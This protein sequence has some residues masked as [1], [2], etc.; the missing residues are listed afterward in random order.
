MK[1]RILA[2]LLCVVMAF[3][4][5]CLG[6][7]APVYAEGE[8]GSGISDPGETGESEIATTINLRTVTVYMTGYNEKGTNTRDGMAVVSLAGKLVDT[9][10][11]DADEADDGFVVT[12]TSAP[13][14]LPADSISFSD[15][16]VTFEPVK[17]GSSVVDFTVGTQAFTVKV[18]CYKPAMSASLLMYKKQKKTLKVTGIPSGTSVKFTSSNPKIA[19]VSSTG[20]VTAKVSGNAVIY[21]SVGT[22]KLG[23][24]VSV[25]TK[26]KYRAINRAVKM[27]RTCRYSQPKR[28]RKGYYDCSSMVWRSYKPEKIYI[29]SKWFA[30]VAASQAKYLARKKKIYCKLSYANGQSMRYRAGDLLFKTGAKNR[31]YKGI[32]H[33]EM[34]RGYTFLGYTQQNRS[35]VTTRWANRL[36]GYADDSWDPGIMGRP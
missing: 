30:P 1:R 13:S 8:S 16:R 33:V 32:Y 12:Y 23:C 25:A 31:R 9:G 36:D 15:D 4:G 5:L 19:T 24:V 28:M 29:G 34:F 2:L 18:T 20:Q 14:V 22:V 35:L 21:A 7:A 11:E 17:A 10:E 27:G 3:G 26:K 6:D